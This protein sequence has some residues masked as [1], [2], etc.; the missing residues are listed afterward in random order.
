M[1]EENLSPPM[2]WNS[3]YCLSESVSDETIRK[4]AA[5]MVERGLAGHGWAYINIDDCWQGKRGGKYN[6]LQGN[7][8]FPDMKGL[9]TY[10]H[11]LGLKLGIY[12]TPWIASYAGFRGRS[13]DQGYEKRYYL[14]ESDRRQ[15]NQVYA[16]CASPH[17]WRIG[18]DWLFPNDVAQ[19]AEWG[20]DYV[21]MDWF[22]N[23][24]PTACRIAKELRSCG[25]EI[26]LSLSNNADIKDAPELMEY[27]N[28]VRIS[29]D[30]HDTWESIRDIGFFHDPRWHRLIRPGHWIDLDMLQVGAIG[31]PNQQNRSF[32]KSN[33]SYEEQKLQLSLW[34][35]LSAP[36]LLTCDI[37]GMDDETFFLVTND[38]IIRVNQEMPAAPPVIR[39]TEEP[40]KIY[41][42]LM[43]DGSVVTAYFNLGEELLPREINLPAPARDLW[44]KAIYPSGRNRIAIPPHGVI[45]IRSTQ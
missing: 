39:E 6:A 9:C 30:I 42:R 12:S 32:R 26:V 23:D 21:K 36:L 44:S 22:P 29:A 27:S 19:W 37:A 33:L 13:A 35:V 25:R 3:W 16:P 4:T 7:E 43:K 2:G 41:E 1:Q 28:L 10:V 11:S 8:R 34:A 24:C 38:D 20:I 14:P 31:N 17:L 45:I 40:L 15:P 5:A 18:A